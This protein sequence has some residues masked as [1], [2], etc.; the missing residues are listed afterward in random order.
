MQWQG[1]LLLYA[2]KGLLTGVQS[3]LG[4]LEHIMNQNIWQRLKNIVHSNRNVMKVS[5]AAK[6]LKDTLLHLHL[7]TRNGHPHR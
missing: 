3:W 4:N 1:A 2:T 6:L 7:T 5:D